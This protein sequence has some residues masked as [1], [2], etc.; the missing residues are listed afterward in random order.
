MKLSKRE[1]LILYLCII[2]IIGSVLYVYVIEP[3]I[4]NIHNLNVK[5]ALKQQE[6]EKDEKLLKEKDKIEAEYKEFYKGLTNEGNINEK[7]ANISIS[8]ESLAKKSGIK[9]LT[10]IMPLSLENE[11]QENGMYQQIRVQL[12]LESS[13]KALIIYIYE[14]LNSPQLFGIQKLQIIP[15][16][17]NP[18]VLRSQIIVTSVFINKEKANKN[19]LLLK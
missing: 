19:E 8:L 12:G 9:Q 4:D 16:N 2:V 3:G 10:N 18:S 5:L 11:V 1:K 14:I 13:L 17:E 15:D 6:L 7:L